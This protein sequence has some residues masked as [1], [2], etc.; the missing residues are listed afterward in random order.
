MRRAPRAGRAGRRHVAPGMGAGIGGRGD[1][2]RLPEAPARPRRWG[3]DRVRRRISPDWRCAPRSADGWRRARRGRTG[4]DDRETFPAPAPGAWI[5][6]CPAI[7]RSAEIMASGSLVSSTE[8]ASARNS[9]LR[10]RAKESAM[11]SRRAMMKMAT[12][13]RMRT[14]APPPPPPLPLLRP[15]LR[16]EPPPHPPPPQFPPPEVDQRSARGARMR[17]SPTS[18]MTPTKTAE[19]TSS[20]TSRFSIWVSSWP[21]TA[22]SSASVNASIS[23]RV[24][25]IEYWP[26]RTPLAKALRASVS[27]ILRRGVA[28]P[29][30]MQRFS[31]RL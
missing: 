26:L 13:M 9:R 4:A 29:R 30:L 20:W 6:E 15:R 17:R 18:E 8:P 16:D 2:G 23:P 1:L 19:T 24:T 12:A 7:L 22:S 28:M 5:S 31:S 10:D 3:R 27:M 14:M 11:A 25:V 21:R